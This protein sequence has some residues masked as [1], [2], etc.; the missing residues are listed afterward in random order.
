M[1]RVYDSGLGNMYLML[2]FHDKGFILTRDF[3]I[4]STQLRP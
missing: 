4:E 3:E 1:P 2:P